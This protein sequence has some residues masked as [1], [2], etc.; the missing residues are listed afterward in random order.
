MAAVQSSTV[1]PNTAEYAGD[2]IQALVLD[3]G[4]SSVRAGFAGEDCP[5]SVV[6]SY[7]GSLPSGSDSKLLFGDNTIHTTLPGLEIKNPMSRD[8]WVEDWDTATKLWEYAITSRLTNIKPGNPMEN[9]L[10]DPVQNGDG[11]VDMEA[12]DEEEK[13]LEEN[14]LLMTEP[15]WNTG[16][17]REKAIEISMEQWG[18]PAFWLAR[19]G[20]LAAFAGGR[21]TALVVDIGASGMT[22]TPVHDGM[23]MKKG[24]QR[25]PLGGDWVSNQCRLLFSTASPPVTI[26]PHYLLT[27]KAPVDAGTRPQ[28]VYKTF[29][30]G[31]EPHDSFRKLQEERVVRDFKETIVHVWQGPGS[32]SSPQNEDIARGYPGKPFEMPDGYN[33]IYNLER[34][35]TVEGMFDLK[36]AYTDSQNPPPQKEHLFTSIISASLSNVDTDL[37]PSLLNNIVLCGAGSQLNGLPERI[38]Q[39]VTGLYPN[40]RVRIH[41]PG[42]MYE[43]RFASWIG[44]SILSSLGT[45]HQMWISRKEYEE[46]GAGVVEKRCK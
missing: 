6:P 5:K 7:Y 22:I 38:N 31:S 43:R 21:S 37:R 35:K 10:N 14:P 17:Q 27:S 8:T 13:C 15:S 45:F 41:A 3:P 9:G 34:F 30:P 24:V 44:G 36:A 40:P 18:C 33:Q 23:V 26:T 32:L 19:D 20:V 28:A 12:V 2:E 42:N 25:S 39:E 16:K 4:Y 1:A 11:D 46:N 29:A